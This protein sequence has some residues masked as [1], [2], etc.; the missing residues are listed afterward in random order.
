VTHKNF[1][2]TGGSRGRWSDHQICRF[3]LK[4]VDRS[5]GT[6]KWRSW[7]KIIKI[8]IYHITPNRVVDRGE[9]YILGHH[10]KFFQKQTKTYYN[11]IKHINTQKLR[12][13]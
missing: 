1:S 6:Q 7:K 3:V 5:G 9:K 8:Y 4:T 2:R 12:K 11:I 10:K 13:K